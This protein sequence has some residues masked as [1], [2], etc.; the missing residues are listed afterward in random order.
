MKLVKQYSPKDFSIEE[1]SFVLSGTGHRPDKLGGYNEESYE[2]L[3]KA[4]RSAIMRI[5]SAEGRELDYIVSGMALG[6]DM[7]LAEVAIEMG[8]KLIAA[9]P[10]RG[11]ESKWPSASGVRYNEL[12]KKA[13]TVVEVCN[14]GYSAWKMHAR[15]HWM[16]DVSSVLLSCFD[17]S[18]GGTFNCVTYA[19]KKEVRVEN[20][21]PEFIST[22]NASKPSV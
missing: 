1:G 19:K 21:Y 17:G 5:E 12:L 20:I 7:C 14:P 15:N 13:H 8:R 9:V 10:F 3:R 22:L 4:I 11:Q 6:F 16:V 18:P 2:V